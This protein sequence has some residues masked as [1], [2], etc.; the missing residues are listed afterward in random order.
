MP[1]LVIGPQR[2]GT[3]AVASVLDALGIDMGVNPISPN[4]DFYESDDLMNICQ[5]IAGDWRHPQTHF[6]KPETAEKI[7]E[8]GNRSGKYGGKSPYMSLVGHHFI[9]KIKNLQVI[10]TVRD[11]D[12]TVKSLHRREQN[13]HPDVCRYIQAQAFAAHASLCAALSRMEIPGARVVYDDLVENPKPII[14]AIAD[15]VGVD[16][17]DLISKA[18]NRINPRLRHY[19]DD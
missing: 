18:I 4:A 7:Q 3:S 13:L 8:W 9:D 15:F 19:G 12:T 10:T 11:F 16:D 5:E 14:E 1:I 6:I 2:T 17:A